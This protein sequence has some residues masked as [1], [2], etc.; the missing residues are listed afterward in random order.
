M[1]GIIK[2]LFYA[3]G[4]L[5][6]FTLKRHYSSCSSGCFENPVG[7]QGIFSSLQGAPGLKGNEGPNGPPGPAV[8]TADTHSCKR[9]IQVFNSVFWEIVIL[10]PSVNWHPTLALVDFEPL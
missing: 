4:C 8:S 3:D 2:V 6:S 1:F 5:N 9:N 10:C 7:F